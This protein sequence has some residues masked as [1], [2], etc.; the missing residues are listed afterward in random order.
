MSDLTIVQLVTSQ[1]GRELRLH[2]HM[3]TIDWLL[4]PVFLVFA[5]F[6]TLIMS[7]IAIVSLVISLV[8]QPEISS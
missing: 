4:L 3:S 5:I 7:V 1:K 2:Q 6:L 8:R